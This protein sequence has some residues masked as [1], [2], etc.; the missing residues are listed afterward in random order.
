MVAARGSLEKF[1]D[2][3]RRFTILKSLE[4]CYNCNVRD[5]AN[6]RNDQHFENEVGNNGAQLQ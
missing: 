1:D 2:I 5:P 3:S 4:W 6:R